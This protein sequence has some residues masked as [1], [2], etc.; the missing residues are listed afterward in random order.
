MAKMPAA[1][2]WDKVTRIN[3]AS[4]LECEK[5]QV[6]EVFD[7]FVSTEEWEVKDK[8][9]EN[10]I[11]VFRVFQTLLKI[12]DREVNIAYN[13]LE[14]IGVKHAKTEKELQAKVLRLEQEHKHSGTGPDSHFLRD[15]IRQ[16][17]TQLEQQKKELTHL[18]KEMGKEKRTNEELVVRAEEA[19]NEVKKLKRENEQ[20]EQDVEF[21][22]GELDQKDPFP[23][24]DENAEAQRKL[25]LANRQ[26]YQC[27]EDLQRAEDENVHLRTQNDQMQ[28]SLEESVREMEKMTDEYNKMKI[29]VQ[30]TDS[31]MD[32]LRKERDHAKLQISE[33]TD[34]IRSM[35]EDDDPVM[36]ALNAKVEEW[37]RVLSGKDDEILVYQQMIRDL[38]EKL[39]SAQLD[40]DKSNI[41]ALQQ[42]IYE[43]C[44]AVQDR[45]NQI[46]ILSEQVEQ[47]TGEMEKHTLLIE[48]L[49]TSTKKDRGIP[50]AIQQRKMEELKSKLEAAETRAEEAVRA[51]KLVE[52]HAEE[53]DKA[54]IEASNRLSQYESGT[55]GLEAAIA[56]IKECKNQIRVRDLEAEAMTKEINQLELRINDLMDENEDFRVKLGL[57]PKQEVDLTEFRRAKDLRQRQYKAEN[58]VLTKEIEQL[59]EERLE[60]KKQIRCIVKEK[61]IPQSSLLLEEEDQALVRPSR[62]VQLQ[63]KRSSTYADEEIQRKNEFLEKELTN[64]ERELELHKTQF[65]I[66]LDELSKV[67]RDLEDALK[68]MRIN[69]QVT[70][71]DSAINIPRLERLANAADIGN[72]SGQSEPVLHLKSQI[73]QLVGRNEELRQEL[74]LA[75]EE[76]TSSFSQHARAKEKVSQ[77]EGELELLRR[78]GS[79]GLVFRPLTLPEGLEPSSTEVISSLNEYAVR[80]LQELKNKEEK[81]KTLAGTLEEYKDKFSV[82]SHQQ[83]LLYKEYLSEKADWQQ[84][85]KTF[86]EMKNKLED[87]QQVDAVKIQEFNKLLDTLQ[88]DPEL[89]RRQLSE[90]SRALTVLKVN[91]KKLTRRYITLLEQEQHLSK[92]NG[93]L[94][95]ES[96]HMQAAV[97]QRIGYLQRYKEMAAYKITAL[98]KALDDSVPSSD[99]E[100][101]NKQYTELTVKYRDMLQRDSHLMQRTTNLEHLESENEYLR[102]Q[103]SAMNKELEITKEKLNTLEQA[104]DNINAI[105]GDANGMDKADKA[106]INKEMVSSARRITTLEMKE[107]NERQRAEHAHKMY[108]HLRNTLKQVEDRNLELE[109]KFAEL[110]KMNVEAQRVER[111]LRDELADS[112][113]KAVSDADRARI[114]ELEKAE[115]ELRIEV[116]KLQEVSD[117]AMM[118]VSAIQARQQSKEKEV[119]ALRR[120]I[121][122]YQSQSDEKALIAKLHQHIVALQLSESASLAKLEAATSHIQQLEAYKL[123]AE[124][125]LDA[126]E[127]SLF[128]ARQEGRNR[129]K[130][131]RQTIQSLRRQFAGALPLPQQEKFSLAMVSVQE[132]RAKALEEKRKAMEERRK[133]E[134]RAEELELRL[135]CLEELISTL[136]DVKGA[137]KVTE[138]HKKMEEARLQELRKGRELVV[139]KEEIRYLKNLME[140]QEQTIHAL[141]EDN[142]QQNMLQEERQLAYDQREVELERQLDQ[143][144]KHQQEILSSAEKYEDGTGSLP[145]PSLPLAHQ[146]E[147]ALAKIREHVRTV[148]D[149][150]ATCKRLDEKLKEKEAAL[151]KAEQN[152]L[153]RDRVINELR[154]RLPAAANRERLL[155]DIAKHEEGQSDNQPTLKLAHQTIKD[156]QGRLDKKEDVLKKYHKQLAQAR[157]DQEE[158]IKRH[159]EELRMLHQKLDLHTDTSLDHFRQTAMELMKKP[160]ISVP[161]TKHLEHL[162][163]LEQTVAEQ[164]ISL[165][166]VTE[167]LKL[168]TA[169]LERQRAAMEILAKKHADEMSKLE[170]DHAAQV[171]NL[172]GETE[173]QTAKMAQMEKEM[174]YLKTEL[175]AQKEANVRSPSNTMKNLVERLKAQLTQKEKQLKALSKA[176]L[177]L[178]AEMTSAAEQ[179]VIASAAQKEESLNVQMLVDRHTKDLKVRVQELNEELQAAKEFARAARGRENTLKEEVDRLNQDLQR[180]LK[181][182]RRLQAEKDERELEIQDH[183]QQVKRLSSALQSQPEPDG[184]GSTIE[185]LH[186][187]IRKLECDLEK[188]AEMKDD[189]G[190]N[191]GEIG[192]WEEGKKWQAKMEKVKNLLKE[193]ERENESLSKQLSTLKDLYGRLEQEKS[194][195]QKKLKGRGVTADQVV[196]VRSTELEKEMEELKKKN[197]DLET[198]ILT[199]KQHQALPRDDAMENL[200]LRNRYLEERLH[201]IESQISK[202]PSSRPSAKISSPWALRRIC[203]VTCDVADEACEG[204]AAQHLSE[205]YS[206]SVSRG[207]VEDPADQQR[208]P[209]QSQ[210]ARE[211]QTS[212][213]GAEDVCTE[214]ERLSPD[215]AEDTAADNTDVTGKEEDASL[216]VEDDTEADTLDH[217]Q[218][219]QGG[220]EVEETWTIKGSEPD[221][222]D[223]SER[224]GAVLSSSEPAV[225]ATGTEALNNEGVCDRDDDDDD[226]DDDVGLRE[227]KTEEAEE[228]ADL[229]D[230]EVVTKKE[231]TEVHNPEPS[232]SEEPDVDGNS[233]LSNH[234]LFIRKKRDDRVRKQERRSLRYLKTSG[235]GTGTP[236]QRDQDLQ[237]ENLKLASENLELRFQVEQTNKDLPRLKNQ[238]ADL[239]EMCSALKKEK[240]EVDKKLTHIRGSGQ[241]GKTIPELEKTIGL[242]KKVVERVQ[243]ENETLKKS[244][245]PAN[246]DKV[247]ALEQETEKLKVDFEKL[248]TQSEAELSS[249]LEAKTKG[250]EKI[251]MEN[252]RLRKEIKREMEATE[253]LR[254]TKATLEATNEKLEAELEETKL[255]LR[256]ALSK[257][258]PEG[259]D[260]KTWKAS[261]VTR[262]FENKMKELEKE[263]SQKTSSLSE[264]KHQLKEVNERE[265]RAQINIRQLED[266]VDMLKSSPTAAKTGGGLTREFQAMRMIN[267][268]LEKENKEL[269]QQLTEYSE[270]YGA[271]SSKLDYGK[272]KHLLQAAQ[273]EK[274]ALQTEIIKLKKELENFDPTFF[275]EIED[276]KY[277]YNLEVKKNILLEEQLK[278]VCDQFG[279]KPELPNVSIG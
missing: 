72:M 64:K 226:D 153:S 183:K 70:L 85:K 236:S 167:K 150:Q 249:K 279:V 272:L 42:V 9:P 161:T 190:K 181:T 256:A 119:E 253:R 94:K 259:A 17:E 265:E 244:S 160:T 115:A 23:S 50:S 88:K 135:R 251:V 104:W 239:K 243:K 250:L 214:Q 224:P 49:K 242:M 182:Q 43:L 192:R 261:V 20:L 216:V 194:A 18:K 71:S 202:E 201:S 129:S 180:S 127:R 136:K 268:E 184:K 83:G 221:P 240:A 205:S 8:S 141:E 80:L 5:D 27:L 7:M 12:K 191:K 263:L 144:E 86:T 25:N 34:R 24:R 59:E 117:V 146:L 61:G 172:T 130:H 58:Q 206:R 131:L 196:G 145:D 126:G 116:S 199:I 273:T 178:R 66:K 62:T 148:S 229:K 237:K 3:P 82:I 163:E 231:T 87:Q 134:G 179:Q 114:A 185:N 93:K 51:L 188:K 200:T 4:L 241:S 166:S 21:Y 109:S 218:D 222:E 52:A 207:A 158:M 13:F 211:T 98:Q 193:K 157:Q 203:S 212:V 6:D 69:Q 26:L 92:E 266:Q 125:R 176:L 175:A 233:E 47:Y 63:P 177:E 149:T 32:Q 137:Q 102:E 73:H 155:A 29:V 132:D 195:L 169:E 48:E 122:D 31:S 67:K 76:A 53:K 235:R 2:K 164:D 270:R 101:A 215:V 81:N 65:H 68:V 39:R 11:Q 22:R 78:S 165:A 170:G 271:A 75:R 46:K 156:L 198:Q 15:E 110:T 74:K 91:E 113:S 162:S 220:S 60:L 14:D 209:K 57:E 274:T 174:N 147:F 97:T 84:E 41:I 227:E 269:K 95:D 103:I 142:V 37:K 143:Y 258:I 105:A 36:A 252:E 33:L 151:W 173:D 133:A 267:T 197:S 35:T 186:K 107:L 10:I 223:P 238:V 96:S 171:K 106:L 77:L 140:E 138:W 1:L 99:L 248:K 254:V 277:N 45:D 19:E 230:K 213:V 118:Q 217:P 28:K 264:L 123:R 54:L 247:A 100:R 90:A 257:A 228:Q 121:L 89:I 245:A 40:L 79:R 168:A 187:K 246:Q 189:H 260:S 159:Q 208:E 30:Q 124:Q 120:Q 38:R 219:I 262:M 210:V 204:N 56:E 278:K 55:Y 16:L 225:A 112:I 128:L 154:L 152:I 255:R 276:L 108:E 111:E 275:E 232:C 139:Q 44:S 234:S